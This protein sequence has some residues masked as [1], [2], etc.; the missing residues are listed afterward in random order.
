[1]GESGTQENRKLQKV[2]LWEDRR[3]RLSWNTSVSLVQDEEAGS[4]VAM[5]AETAVFRSFSGVIF[6]VTSLLVATRNPHKAREFRE[7]LGAQFEVNDL[8]TN[9]EIP[10]TIESGKTF[11]ENAILKAV[12]VSKEHPGLVIADDSGLE[13][14]ALGGAPGIFS[15]RYAGKHATDKENVAKLLSEL[16]RVDPPRQQRGARFCC[17]IALARDGKLLNTFD[18]VVEG[19]IVES[20]RGKQGFGYDPVF[21][22]NGFA[23]T[24]AELSADRKNRISHRAKALEKVKQYL[25]DLS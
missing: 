3:P 1:L 25:R 11:A 2:W 9:P 17:V 20:P 24:F 15:A 13:V 12:A 14:D 16:A 7:I 18:G 21:V 10:E 22:P 4:L 23:K 19:G 8:S 6:R 5:T